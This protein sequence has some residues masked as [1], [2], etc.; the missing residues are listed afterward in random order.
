MN[1]RSGVK[2]VLVVVV[3]G[4]ALLL[5]WLGTNQGPLAPTKVTPSASCMA[6][7]MCPPI[8]PAAP[9]TATLIIAIP[10]S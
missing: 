2:A 7:M 1:L 5:G 9:V 10:A 8:R 6:V 4:G 3:I